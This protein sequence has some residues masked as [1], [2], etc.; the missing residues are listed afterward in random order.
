MADTRDLF[1]VRM[2][3]LRL[4]VGSVEKGSGVFYGNNLQVQWRHQKKKNEGFGK[5]D[6]ANSS[7]HDNWTGIID[8]DM[9]DAVR[10]HSKQENT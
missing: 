6:T 7:I 5:T 4:Q 9:L 8:S 10:E 3:P 1:S 2:N